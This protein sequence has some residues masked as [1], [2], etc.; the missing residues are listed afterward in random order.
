MSFP[1]MK[2]I[3]GNVDRVLSDNTG[4]RRSPNIGI[5]RVCQYGVVVWFLE[6]SRIM[7]HNIRTK[8]VLNGP[9]RQEPLPIS[10]GTTII[11]QF[12]YTEFAVVVAK[13]KY[14][15]GRHI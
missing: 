2:I 1:D 7:G 4:I 15:A 12:G 8:T 10:W 13:V 9:R 14:A 5:N 11:F 6:F 3:R